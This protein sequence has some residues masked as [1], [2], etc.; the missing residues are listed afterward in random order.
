MRDWRELEPA[1]EETR[2]AV[3]GT[4][5]GQDGEVEAY[6]ASSAIRTVKRTSP[7]YACAG[8]RNLCLPAVFAAEK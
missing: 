3:P 1:R 6:I 4:S 8:C 2:E 5:Y 7:Y